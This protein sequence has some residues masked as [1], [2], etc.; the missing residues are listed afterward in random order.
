MGRFAL[1]LD[2]GGYKDV[3]ERGAD[4]VWT[5]D[6]F[7][8]PAE[9]QKA[10]LSNTDAEGFYNPPHSQWLMMR[11]R[12]FDPNWFKSDDIDSF[13]VTNGDFGFATGFEDVNISTWHPNKIPGGATYAIAQRLS[14]PA[15]P[16]VAPLDV[17]FDALFS[18]A[19]IEMP[20]DIDVIAATGEISG[21]VTPFFQWV[22]Q[23]EGM[24]G[25]TFVFGFGDMALVITSREMVLVRTPD[26]GYDDWEFLGST[27]DNFKEGLQAFPWQQSFFPG[28][29]L[30]FHLRPLLIYPVGWNQLYLQP[31]AAGTAEPWIITTRDPPP[32]DQKSS[33]VV[34]QIQNGPWWYATVPSATLLC[35]L[36]QVAYPNSAQ[37]IEI[38]SGTLAEEGEFF[39]LTNEYT[40]QNDFMTESQQP[41]VH[42]DSIIHANDGAFIFSAIP[43]GIEAISDDG[44][45]IFIVVVD[46]N[47]AAWVSDGTHFKGALHILMTS[48]N[49]PSTLLNRLSP[50]IR[51]I[52]V[53]FPVKLADD[54]RT[55]TILEDTDFKP[56][57]EVET[58]LHDTDAKDLKFPLTQSGAAIL[59]ATGIDLRHDYAVELREDKGGNLE[60]ETL[61]VAGW[62]TLPVDVKE[63]FAEDVDNP[64]DDTVV[65]AKGILQRADIDWLYTAMITN[66]ANAGAL[67]HTE[68]V[69]FALLQAGFDVD[70]SEKV[71]IQFPIEDGFDPILPG[72]P[73][74]NTG[75]TGE[76]QNSPYAPKPDES[77]LDF[78]KRIR[79]E[80]SGTGLLFEDLKGK[81][82]YVEDPVQAVIED[83]ATLVLDAVIYR[84]S[85]DAIDAGQDPRQFMLQVS[86]RFA[87]PVRANRIR[88][89]PQ[90]KDLPQYICRDLRSVNDPTYENYV[91]RWVT[92]TRRPTMAVDADSSKQISRRT[93]KWTKRRPQV[94]EVRLLMPPWEIGFQP[95]PEG[96]DCNSIIT[97]DGLGDW[98][99]VHVNVKGQGQDEFGPVVLTTLTCWKVP[100]P[101]PPT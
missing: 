29:A 30:G 12:Q 98:Q 50:Q 92:L 74:T 64:V 35:Q 58:S 59:R 27:K 75:K 17:A 89:I 1:F 42:G 28:A 55:A 46:E 7:F 88:L 34:Q 86:D 32:A 54:D 5:C 33:G 61:R 18:A 87:K 91:G 13:V 51:E 67:E 95:G 60:Y 52:Q 36:Q 76:A 31:D 99:V 57:W 20:A 8:K 71:F 15:A 80:W 38:D 72:T 39:N 90:E 77:M 41:I 6:K 49:T 4:F 10:L 69:S 100:L 3:A 11:P 47:H 101:D 83:S 97:L 2:A 16:G 79:E 26:L 21:G 81:A 73:A 44:E 66:P 63:L 48:A 19:G 93:L 68:A 53:K 62:A 84:T 37:H 43:G 65:N 94:R 78:C 24:P 45:S 40:P 14:V 23:Q 82:F 85:Q 70:D 56:E 96:I 22:Q 25:E 9:G